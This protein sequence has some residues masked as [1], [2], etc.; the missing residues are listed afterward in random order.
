M[1][2]ILYFFL[3]VFLISCK[4]E[5]KENV[6]DINDVLPSS[7]RYAE[8]RDSTVETQTVLFY[9]SLS[10]LSQFISDTTGLVPESIQFIDS[11]WLPERLDHQRV[12]KWRGEVKG[13]EMVV[14]VFSFRDSA[15]M[16]NTLFNWLDCFGVKC[17]SLQ[18]Y[19]QKKIKGLPFLLYATA[20]KIV[21]LQSDI[22]D[23]K[24]LL[25]NLQEYFGKDLP[26]Y[27]LSQAS[28]SKTKW[29]K[30]EAKSWKEIEKLEL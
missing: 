24:Q 9:D 8:G 27:V 20:K 2:S 3:F 29:W 11:V 15:N 23:E 5:K 25:I 17:T 6:I 28:S 18:L 14:A 19:E 13:K 4:S 10:A 22:L 26:K 1:K 16:K 7:E 21:F 12:E 30:W